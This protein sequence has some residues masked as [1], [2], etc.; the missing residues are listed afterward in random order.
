MLRVVP[1]VLLISCVVAG[2]RW[3]NSEKIVVPSPCV[4]G[5]ARKLEFRAS[6]CE[7]SDNSGYDNWNQVG[8]LRVV[9]RPSVIWS[10][11]ILVMITGV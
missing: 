2:T 4:A 11:T 6:I 7:E 3:E 9:V 5:C 10:R 1:R 8:D